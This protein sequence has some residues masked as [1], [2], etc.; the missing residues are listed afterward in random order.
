M[1]NVRTYLQNIRIG[2]EYAR[3]DEEITRL[4]SFFPDAAQ[5]IE[6]PAL[7]PADVLIDLYGEDL[8][9]R[10]YTTIDLV[11][12]ELML[13]PDFT[14]PIV[15]SHAISELKRADYMYAGPV[16]RRQVPGSERPSEYLQ[17]GFE[18]F[19]EM[20]EPKADAQVFSTF[21]NALSDISVTPIT[22]DVSLL[23]AAIES[24]NTTERRKSA[25][26]RHV[27]RPKRFNQLLK[28]FANTGPPSELRKSLLDINTQRNVENY[29]ENTGKYV[30]LRS[31]SEIIFRVETLKI[32]ASTPRLKSN[33]LKKIESI[34]SLTTTVSDAADSLR[35][36]A[37]E[38]DVSI[39][40]LS[41]RADAMEAEGID[42]TQIKFDASYGLATMEY[43]DGF[44]F[45][46][47]GEDR[48]DLPQIAQGGRYNALTDILGAQCP[49]IGGIIRPDTLLMLKG[50]AK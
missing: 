11:D 27:W 6:L 3:L 9:V 23:F 37:P 31:I 29:I 1:A 18:S 21:A 25:L 22:G 35:K 13:R 30:G 2:D 24:L 44:V 8:R 48:S 19:G 47:Y 32:E 26:R 14:V 20:D 4:M 17:V 34:L 15:Q 36:V 10:A 16:W 12:G 50:G 7:L 39:K 38:L 28:R 46:F 33:D 42:T 41:A 40:N 45:G 49:A 5:H 43:Y